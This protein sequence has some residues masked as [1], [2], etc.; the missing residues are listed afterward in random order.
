MLTRVTN[1]SIT[2]NAQFNLQTGLAALSK[3]QNQA[4]S[5]KAISVPSD[6]PAGTAKALQ[7][8]GQQASTS[9]YGRNIA[10]GTAWLNTI[11][12]TLSTVTSIL[13][14]I[15]DLTVQGANDGAMSPT[16][17]QAIATEL[18]SLKGELLKQ[19]NTSYLGRS[20]FA[21]NSD[22]GVAF[23]ADG[24]F[25]GA[26]GS[27]VQR[28]VD[29]NTT[30]RVDAD[31][32]AVFG[33][34]STTPGSVFTLVDNIISDLQSGVN[35]GARLTEIDARQQAIS[36]QQSIIGTTEAQ[37][38]RASQTNASQT[39]SLEAQRSSVE[40]L[41]L[42]KTILDLQT[43]QTTYQ[44]SLGVTAKVLQ[45]TLMDFLH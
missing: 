22:A 32:S 41:D 25:N 36:A 42:A 40:D 31:G 3:L 16:S 23:N 21:G 6:D 37:M 43:Q 35:V 15:R 26:A 30:V 27:T 20:V 5:Q 29:A 14:R 7:I 11:D 18:T 33:T 28:R 10:D 44:T 8:H 2:R 13:G 17:K 39:V 24:T 19:S 34:A 1:Q 38:D 45:P 9:Q 4:S 12:S